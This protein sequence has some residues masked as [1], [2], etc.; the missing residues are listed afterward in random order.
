MKRKDFS[1][2][3]TTNSQIP[4]LF[5][6]P[7]FLSGSYYVVKVVKCLLL[8]QPAALNPLFW[9]FVVTKRSSK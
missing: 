2:K 5:R 3:A 8:Q 6:I 4:L 7:F 9:P 1:K